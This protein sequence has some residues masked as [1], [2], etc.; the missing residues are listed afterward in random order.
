MRFKNARVEVVAKELAL[1]GKE[2]ASDLR[3]LIK[4]QIDR[5]KKEQSKKDDAQ[6][7]FV[8][9][10]TQQREADRKSWESKLAR[11]SQDLKTEPERLR[12]SFD[13]RAARVEPLG[14]VYLSS[15]G[16]N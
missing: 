10:E 16:G 14:I 12:Q 3:T 4:S 13:I 7:Q 6:P 11:L 9:E 2:E 1:R 8:F 15:N 5:I